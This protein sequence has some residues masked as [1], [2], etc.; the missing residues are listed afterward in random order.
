MRKKLISEDDFR[1]I[2]SDFRDLILICE[3]FVNNGVKSR[4][5][6]R[7][8]ENINPRFEIYYNELFSVEEYTIFYFS[9]TSL[10]KNFIFNSVNGPVISNNQK[11]LISNYCLTLLETGYTLKGG[12][13]NNYASK[14]FNNI[15]ENLKNQFE[16][17][18]KD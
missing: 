4:E 14:V 11:R 1:T 16:V 18:A 15:K 7:S 3:E 17:L 2:K 10:D 13:T 12:I 5:E 6:K 8:L 9:N